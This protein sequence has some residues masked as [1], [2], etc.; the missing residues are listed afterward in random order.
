MRVVTFTANEQPRLRDPQFKRATNTQLDAAMAHLVYK[1]SDDPLTAL[2]D[3]AT[4]PPKHD[5]RH[6]RAIIRS[7]FQEVQPTSASVRPGIT[8][9]APL[10]L[11]RLCQCCGTNVGRHQE[12]FL[13]WSSLR[14]NGRTVERIAIVASA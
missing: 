7:P 9:G 5:L 3:T 14:R 4:E 13:P 8:A 10:L 2:R 1:P 12:P 6:D 11:D